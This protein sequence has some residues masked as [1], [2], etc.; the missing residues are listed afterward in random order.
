MPFRMNDFI[1][2]LCERKSYVQTL[3]VLVINNCTQRSSLVKFQK[4]KRQVNGRK[5]KGVLSFD[6]NI[7]EEIKDYRVEKALPVK[8]RFE[9]KL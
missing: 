4:F 9:K 8:E 1:L 7:E 6:I 3:K 2:E 5:R